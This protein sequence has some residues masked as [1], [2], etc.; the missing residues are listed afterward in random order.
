MPTRFAS[1]SVLGTIV[2]LFAACFY[3]VFVMPRAFSESFG[4][5]AAYSQNFAA[6]EGL[7]LSGFSA[8]DFLS[9]DIL[10]YFILLGLGFDNFSSALIFLI[11]MQAFLLALIFSVS[12]RE[13]NQSVLMAS[14]FLF[15]LLNPKF[16]ELIFF[17]A[18]QGLSIL[19]MFVALYWCPFKPLRYFCIGLSLACHASSVVILVAQIISDISAIFRKDIYFVISAFAVFAL[20][21]LG[22]SA[23]AE[24]RFVSGWQPRPVYTMAILATIS[25]IFWSAVVGSGTRT[26]FTLIFLCLL[27]F[28]GPVLNIPTY[29]FLGPCL[30]LFWLNLQSVS[31]IR[32]SHAVAIAVVGCFTVANLALWL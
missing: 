22:I 1:A 18:R 26:K 31:V 9:D 20:C 32:L 29:R 4:D 25:T 24:Y 28:C 5:F 10:F 27:I 3:S 11:T 6:F 7:V 17:N 16:F 2:L 13:R 23:A 21:I 30:L 19:L 14:L 15:T 8:A 12:H